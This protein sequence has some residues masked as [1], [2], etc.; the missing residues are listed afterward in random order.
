MEMDTVPEF[1][2]GSPVEPVD[3]RFRDAFVA[4]R[5]RRHQEVGG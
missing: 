3:L 5:D 1:Y 2:V 4:E